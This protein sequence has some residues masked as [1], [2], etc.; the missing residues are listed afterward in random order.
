MTEPEPDLDP[1]P[2]PPHPGRD[3]DPSAGAD[4]ELLAELAEDFSSRLRRGEHPTAEE[5]ACQHPRLADRLEKTLAAVSLMEDFRRANPAPAAAEQ[6]G[7]LVGS[8]K[9]LERIGEGGF[10]VVFMA[11]QQSPVRRKVALK[12]IKAGLDTKQVIARFEVERQALA[13][14]QHENIA[15]VLDAGTTDAGR[16]YF[17]MELVHGVPIT[18]YCDGNRLPP[19]RRL[20]LFLAVCRAVQHAHTKGV[21][22]RDI[23]PTNVLVTLHDGVPVP[24]V[25]DFG[26]AKATGGAGQQPLTDRTLF[27]QFAQMVGTPLYMSP[28]QAEMSGLD[29]D[30]RSDV[31]SLGVLLYELLT[32]TTP[33][34]K[35]RLRQAAHDEVRRI[36]REEEP[37]PPSTRIGTLSDEKRASVSADRKTD[38]RRLGQLVR[39]ELDWIVMKALEKDRVRRYDSPSGLATDVQRYLAD[40]AVH[41]CPPNA[42]YRFR[43]LLRRNK[44][45][46]ATAAAVALSLVIGLGASTWLFVREKHARRLAVLS[47]QKA[48]T[49]AR[50]SE[51]VAAFMTDMLRGVGPSVALGRDT[52]MLR[53]VLDRTAQRLNKMGDEPAVEAGLRGTLADVYADL[54]QYPEAV[55][56]G[57]EALRLRKTLAGNDP[58]E[59]ARSMNDLAHVFYRQGAYADAERLHREALAIRETRLGGSHPDVAISMHNLAG[60][61]RMQ[62]QAVKLA[63]AE[64]LYRKALAVRRKLTGNDHEDVADSLY[65]LGM[66]L[67]ATGQPV[68]AEAAHREALAIRRKLFG[69]E[70]PDVANSLDRLGLMMLEQRKYA[71]AE[72]LLRDAAQMSRRLFGKEH[73]HLL[74]T[75]STLGTV[76]R[77][78]GKVAEADA[79]LRDVQ[80]DQERGRAEAIESCRESL[81]KQ[82]DSADLNK[83]LGDLLA[84]QRN[85]LDAEAA[86]TQATRLQPTLAEAWAGRGACRLARG[87]FAGAVGPYSEAIRL[88]P[89]TLWYWHERAFAHLMLEEHGKSVADHSVA[90]EMQRNNAGLRLRRGQSYEAL[91]DFTKAEADYSK[92]IDLNPQHFG[93]W[94]ARARLY[95]HTGQAEKA[96]ADWADTMKRV[97]SDINAIN[98]FAWQLV[99]DPDPRLRRPTEAIELAQKG[100]TA[101]PT[102][103]HIWNTLGVALY[104]D[105]RWNEA[106]VAL[107]KSIRIKRGGDIVD[108]LFMAMAR[109]RAGDPTAHDWFDK[110]VLRM[111]DV[112]RPDSEV[113]RFRAEA[114]ELFGRVPAAP[115]TRPAE[116]TPASAAL[117]QAS[118]ATTQPAPP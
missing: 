82:P 48:T 87:D 118:P 42:F 54:G 68:E 96:Q 56:M 99:A 62:G 102:A 72:V 49:E 5:Y 60:A 94:Y 78:Q 112:P 38:A 28:E 90:I 70:H 91:G 8:Y 104:R 101:M 43:K 59:V 29:V 53:E 100:V 47:E 4:E 21:I 66:L 111:K 113:V 64:P 69:S 116:S 10:G 26:V 61:L 52:R 2:P 16:P 103:P 80:A 40:E 74:D 110:A 14:M 11:E 114:D 75:I 79:L 67:R 22:H 41:A 71:D 6:P 9:L 84:S 36:I 117:P 88:K 105:G 35:E 18:E 24:K 108:L 20:E 31:Y 39:R 7:S 83:T 109:E 50:K 76:L 15:K 46:F 58:S 57:H 93:N 19:R 92:A 33:F 77:V 86:F 37:P 55:A 81:R 32:G 30:T 89:D 97:P 65:D 3:P 27:T 115:G 34:D 63:E 107:E 25:I 13:M 1:P 23:K 12:L 73:R 85:Y 95:W 51:R 106:I 98:T 17:V 45:P 44:L